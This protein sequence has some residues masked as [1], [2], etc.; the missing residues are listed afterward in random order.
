MGGGGVS[1]GQASVERE[2]IEGVTGWAG[3]PGW[4]G[5][6]PPKGRRC[7][8]HATRPVCRIT[9]RPSGASGCLPT[10]NAQFPFDDPLSSVLPLSAVRCV[11]LCCAR[12]LAEQPSHPKT[13]FGG[14]T[15]PLTPTRHTPVAAAQPHSSSAREPSQAPLTVDRDMP[16]ATARPFPHVL[17]IRCRHAIPSTRP[18]FGRRSCSLLAG[19][20]NHSLIK[21][22]PHERLKFPGVIHGA[23][24]GPETNARKLAGLPP[25]RVAAVCHRPRGLP[26]RCCTNENLTYSTHHPPA[27]IERQPNQPALPPHFWPRSQPEA[28]RICFLP[29]VPITAA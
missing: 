21:F 8:D 2:K 10:S 7:R 11:W 18:C 1:D 16:L 23:R 9:L 12:P 29:P 26:Q 14:H 4:T 15:H 25:T 17:P 24:T 6:A 5:W 3:W 20:S 22:S 27:P 19:N 28:T 13:R